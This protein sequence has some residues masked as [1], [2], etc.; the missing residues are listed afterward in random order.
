MFLF[1][2]ARVSGRLRA[3]FF[4][5]AVIL[6]RQCAD[7]SEITPPC[8]M[9][10]SWTRPTRGR[11]MS[12]RGIPLSTLKQL[13]FPLNVSFAGASS[14]RKRS[15][16]IK[17]NIQFP[18]ETSHIR[19]CT[20]SLFRVLRV[21]IQQIGHRILL[22]FNINRVHHF[23]LMIFFYYKGAILPCFYWIKSKSCSLFKLISKML[24]IV[25]LHLTLWTSVTVLDNWLHC[26]YGTFSARLNVSRELFHC[27]FALQY[28]YV[29]TLLL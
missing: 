18:K 19:R 24:K 17:R 28:T 22:M 10:A 25:L 27:Y 21:D 26:N 4:F 11:Q 7:F 16:Q 29:Q 23:I 1:A 12:V 20:V 5:V 13:R 14:G 15:A 9:F 6:C 3:A 8:S 2:R